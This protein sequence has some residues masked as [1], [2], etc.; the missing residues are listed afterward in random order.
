[1]TSRERVRRVLSRQLPD[2][3]P[4]GLGGAYDAQMIA[5]TDSYEDVYRKVFGNIKTL[6]NGGNYIFGGVHNLPG[7]VPETHL[8]AMLDAYRDARDY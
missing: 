4:N 7:D 3:V 6:G 8:K 2:R 5:R 1:M